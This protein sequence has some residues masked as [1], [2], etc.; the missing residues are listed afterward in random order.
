[1]IMEIFNN[2]NLNNN[3]AKPDD[4][5]SLYLR[6]YFFI[7]D[8]E[9]INVIFI[10]N[11]IN[12][13]E[14]DLNIKYKFIIDNVY[15]LKSNISTGSGYIYKVFK[16]INYNKDNIVVSDLIYLNLWFFLYPFL[17]D[18]VIGRVENNEIYKQFIKEEPD[19]IVKL[20]NYSI[21]DYIQWQNSSKLNDLIT[22]G[23][24]SFLVP[25]DLNL[26]M[27][28]KRKMTLKTK[29]K[30]YEYDTQD[31]GLLWGDILTFK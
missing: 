26:I 6:R 16:N 23:I 15:D 31:I 8:D 21:D 4:Y 13:D 9:D 14:K 18:E 11:Y 29:D 17:R 10:N 2:L 30:I 5:F 12:K 20:Q 27:P 25:F 3:I 7:K 22:N 24:I 1:M 28:I 19:D